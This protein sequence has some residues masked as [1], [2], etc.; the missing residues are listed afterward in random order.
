MESILLQNITYL[1]RIRYTDLGDGVWGENEMDYILFIK[2]DVK[3]NPNP[4][5]IS[6]ISFVPQ[7]EFD[8]YIPTIG[9]QLTPWFS[10]ISKHRLKLWWK[11]LDDIAKYQD[12]EKIH[13]LKP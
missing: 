8:S 2:Q 4:N 7:T 12:H 13:Y 11:N 5:E 1:T 10:L 6:E 3:I 9:A